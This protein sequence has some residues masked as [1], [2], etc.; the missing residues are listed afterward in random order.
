MVEII[1]VAATESCPASELL[2]LVP[3]V[4]NYSAIH[5]SRVALLGHQ[6]HLT[7]AVEKVETIVID[8]TTN[9]PIHLN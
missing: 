3:D 9:L 6:H 2:S 8:L 7:Y 5:R 1:D 4:I